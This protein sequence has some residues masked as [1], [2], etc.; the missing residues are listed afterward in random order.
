MYF[1]QVDLR[2]SMYK[3]YN[4]VRDARYIIHVYLLKY[5]VQVI[6]QPLL[7]LHMYI[8]NRVLLGGNIR[9][10]WLSMTHR[11]MALKGLEGNMVCRKRVKM[12]YMYI[13]YDGSPYTVH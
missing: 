9:Q 10:I 11:K 3:Q 12:R 5:V 1:P 7:H 6:K 4:Y 2:A 13:V 8:Y